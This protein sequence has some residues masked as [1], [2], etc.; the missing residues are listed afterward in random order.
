[1]SRRA[2]YMYGALLPR[3][4]YGQVDGG[5]GK[6]TSI[7]TVTLIPPTDII[8]TTGETKTID[9]VQI[10]FQMAPGTEAP[11]EMLFYFPQFKALCAAEDATTLFT[12]C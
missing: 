11:S 4:I 10:I 6:T 12:T 2:I 8:T 9:G 7:G 5:L 1:M 3:G